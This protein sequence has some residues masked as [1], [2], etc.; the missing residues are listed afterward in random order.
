MSSKN[1]EIMQNFDINNLPDLDTCVLGAL[2]LFSDLKIP[3]I[4]FSFK[5][6]L[7][8]GSGNAEATGR[9]LFSD[10]DAIFASESNFQ[11]KL[12]DIKSIDGVILISASGGKDA[13]NIAKV[14][15]KYEKKVILM[16]NNPAAPAIKYSSNSFVFPRQKEPYTYNTSTY[17][18]MILSKTCEDPKKILEFIKKEVDTLNFPSFGKHKKYYLIVPHSFSE[19]IRMLNVK[20]IELFGRELARDV[21]TSDYVRHAT[22]VIPSDEIFISFGDK[23]TIWGEKRENRLNIPLPEN[24]DYGAMLAISYYVIGK[25]QKSQ[26]PYFKKNIVRYTKEV[27]KL[28]K[29]EIKAIVG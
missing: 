14:S 4:T 9:I 19:I 2:E 8:V 28:F 1:K 23:N 11:K 20:F 16:T 5:K 10:I 18:S 15:R 25:I 6:P 12:K 17:L 22:T 21:E 24:A 26:K 29:E 27:S 3:E 7:V 13:P